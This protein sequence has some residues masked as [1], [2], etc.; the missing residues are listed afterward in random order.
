M[1]EKEEKEVKAKGVR[2]S[3]FVTLNNFLNH[4]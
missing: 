3:Y 2:V 4:V 1:S